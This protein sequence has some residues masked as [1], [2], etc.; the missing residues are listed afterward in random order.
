MWHSPLR[1]IPKNPIY[2]RNTRGLKDSHEVRHKKRKMKTYQWGKPQNNL[3]SL[4][5][6]NDSAFSQAC[7]DNHLHDIVIFTYVTVIE[8]S[9]KILALVFQT[10]VTKTSSQVAL[11]CSHLKSSMK[12]VLN[13]LRTSFS[14]R[15][16]KNIE[17]TD[18]MMIL[19]FSVKMLT[20]TSLF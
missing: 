1:L 13:D 19:H 9:L 20:N 6:G 2:P 14:E 8:G 17:R 15:H 18:T 16:R 5:T 11:L 12:I 7:A 3:P 4:K 10:S